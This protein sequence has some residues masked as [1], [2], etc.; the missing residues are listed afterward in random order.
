M[1]MCS[2][3]NYIL[4]G[5]SYMGYIGTLVLVNSFTITEYWSEEN[6]QLI[7]V[8]WILWSCGFSSMVAGHD[9]V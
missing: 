7:G 9:I 1:E 5:Y 4:L 2:V 6:C 8:T 3:G